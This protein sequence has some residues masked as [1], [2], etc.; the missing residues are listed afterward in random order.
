V[1]IDCPFVDRRG[2]FQSNMSMVAAMIQLAASLDLTTVAEIIDSEAA[3]AALKA[4]GCRYGQGYYFSPPLESAAA[5]EKLRG[6]EPLEPLLGSQPPPTRTPVDKSMAQ[7]LVMRRLQDPSELGT[8]E[9][10]IVRA[11]PDISSSE[12]VIV[13]TPLDASSTIVL[14]T[15]DLDFSGDGDDEE[16]EDE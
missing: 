1:K 9:T 16:D 6:Q 15:E 7:T 14:S 2:V 10:V 4:M 5:Y 12:T 13:R 8:A 3:A 11:P